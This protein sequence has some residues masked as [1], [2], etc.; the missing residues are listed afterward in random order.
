MP[1]THVKSKLFVACVL[2]WKVSDDLG[3]LDNIGTFN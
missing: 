3:G 1:S 2:G